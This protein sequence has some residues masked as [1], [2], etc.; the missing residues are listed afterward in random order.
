MIF[1]A[2]MVLGAKLD[3]TIDWGAWLDGRTI[4]S[5]SWAAVSGLT[6]NSDTVNGDET[7]VR[8]T[9][10]A[11]GVY[12]PSVTV[13]LNTTEE[14][15]RGLRLHVLTRIVVQDLAK[16]IGAKFVIDAL[17]WTDYLDGD[18]IST[19]SWSVGAGLSILSG[20]TTA[21]PKLQATAAGVWYATEHIVT[22]SGQ[23]DERAV[24]VTVRGF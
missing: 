7:R 8:Y 6:K 20:G 15:V 11:V 13:T 18:T 10:S 12:L 3:F 5:A 19:R 1:D 16:A 2:A 24:V 21:T 9:P 4:S 22:A 14:E 23:E 17:P